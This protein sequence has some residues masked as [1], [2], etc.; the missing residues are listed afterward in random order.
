MMAADQPLTVPTTVVEY[1]GLP[2]YRES[3]LLFDRLGLREDQLN[4]EAFDLAYT[5]YRK[6]TD[7]EKEILTLID[8]SRSSAVE[9]LFVI[10]MENEQ[11]L[12]RTHV[13][14]G[15]NSGEEYAVSFSN[16]NGSYK[17]SPG[18]FLTDETYH[19]QAGYSLR[20]E[21]IEKG[22]NDK[23]RQRAIVMHPSKYAD[24]SVAA[25]RGM[26]GRSL[27]CPA[28]PPKVSRDIIDTIKEGSVLF[29]YPGQD[30]YASLSP[31]LSGNDM[32]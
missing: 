15:R 6:I 12:F 26:L 23:A 18:F 21:G 31:L 32:T 25:R 8:Y 13:A 28:I 5:G 30:T 4:F 22:I 1:S 17:S 29:I 11:V 10:D 20:L 14:H 9:R 2:P 27:G 7:R 16:V 19:G 24:P 3:S